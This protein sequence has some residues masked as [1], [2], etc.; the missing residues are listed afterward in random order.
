MS[1]SVP[2]EAGAT[3]SAIAGDSAPHRAPQC[4]SFRSHLSVELSVQRRH[5]MAVENAAVPR[6]SAYE[7]AAVLFLP[8]IAGVLTWCLWQVMG[9]SFGT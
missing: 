4:T 9:R 6:P 5:N 3:P 1:T 2:S 7:K 8:L